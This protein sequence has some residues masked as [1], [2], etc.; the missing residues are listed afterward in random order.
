MHWFVT[1]WFNISFLLD[2][3]WS[4]KPDQFCDL[5]HSILLKSG[6]NER[7][8]KVDLKNETICKL[9]HL[10]VSRLSSCIFTSALLPVLFQLQNRWAEATSVSVLWRVLHT[11]WVLRKHFPM[12]TIQKKKKNKSQVVHSVA[13][14]VDLLVLSK[15]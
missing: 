5:T 9:H 2:T 15:I 11:L 3:L 7:G 13:L 14:P 10:C 6:S 4:R 1:Y 12:V 8:L